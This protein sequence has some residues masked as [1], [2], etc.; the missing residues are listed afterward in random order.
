MGA[1]PRWKRIVFKPSG[2]ALAGDSGSGSTPPT[3]EQ[4]AL[5]IISVR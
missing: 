1:T 2:E 5:E 3:L 4:T